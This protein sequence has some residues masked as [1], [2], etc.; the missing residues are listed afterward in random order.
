[1]LDHIQLKYIFKYT[2]KKNIS[3]FIEYTQKE[4]YL[5]K[6]VGMLINVLNSVN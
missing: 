5:K 6:T 4:I 2:F 3:K 1:M